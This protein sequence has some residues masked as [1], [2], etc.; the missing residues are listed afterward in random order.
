[1]SDDL[2]AVGTAWKILGI[3]MGGGM[4]VIGF[5]TRRAI[6]E[7]DG[8]KDSVER[9]S[10]NDKECKLDLANFRTEVATTYAKEASVQLSL[11]RIHDR[12]E[13]GF[14]EIRADIKMLIGKVK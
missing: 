11:A 10:D 4:A 5:F 7:V 1:M 3:I 9:L 13:A 14:E 2:A 6:G 8:L 12:L